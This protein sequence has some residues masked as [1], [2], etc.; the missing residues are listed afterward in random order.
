MS[1]VESQA[2]DGFNEL[3]PDNRTA[4]AR[5]AVNEAFANIVGTTVNNVGAAPHEPSAEHRANNGEPVTVVSTAPNTPEGRL[6]VPELADLMQRVG[7]NICGVRRDTLMRD[8]P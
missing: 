4:A 3:T 8:S 6:G 1:P 5:A 2:Y 7:P